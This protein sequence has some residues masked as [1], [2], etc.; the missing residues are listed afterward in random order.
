[1]IHSCCSPLQLHWLRVWLQAPIC[2]HAVLLAHDAVV[3]MRA[4][5]AL[6][7]WWQGQQQSVLAASSMC[8]VAMSVAAAV[9]EPGVQ[10][11]VGMHACAVDVQESVSIAQEQE[12]AGAAGIVGAPGGTMAP[13]CSGA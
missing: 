6:T 12:C 11:A 1:M 5:H 3:M 13:V 2:W 4:Q 8:A 10:L 9:V 7:R